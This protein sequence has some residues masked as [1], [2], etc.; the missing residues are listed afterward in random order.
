MAESDVGTLAVSA[1]GL[2]PAGGAAVRTAQLYGN[3]ATGERVYLDAWAQGA[4]GV[5]PSQE[6]LEG[7]E[8]LF[9]LEGSLQYAGGRAGG[10]CGLC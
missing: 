9:V 7:G 5:A 6:A 3:A 10:G 8:E 2:L 4:A 1:P